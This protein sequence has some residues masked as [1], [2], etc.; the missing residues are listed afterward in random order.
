MFDPSGMDR[1]FSGFN[2]PGMPQQQQQQQQQQQPMMM[3]GYGGFLPN[4]MNMGFGG[5]Y[6]NPMAGMSNLSQF[7]GMPGIHG[8]PQSPFGGLAPQVPS[9]PTQ[10][11][12]Q[13][14]MD[15]GLLQRLLMEQQG[16]G[17]YSGSS[18]ATD[19]L[20]NL[21]GGNFLGQGAGYGG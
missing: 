6:M 8:S 7:S 9:G 15:P 14:Q 16:R 21:L 13:Q 4:F 2:M 1:L 19:T 18:V 20:Q 3:G 12:P 5:M 11:Q 10:G 17:L